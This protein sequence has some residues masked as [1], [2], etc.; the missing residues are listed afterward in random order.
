MLGRYSNRSD[1]GERIGEVLKSAPDAAVRP[2]IRTSPRTAR[3]LESQEIDAL[4]WAYSNGATVYELAQEFGIHRSTVS[5]V[6]EREGVA[7]RQRLLDGD[8]L[9]LARDLYTAGNTLAQVGQ[10]LGVSRSTVAH[11]LKSEGVQLRRRTA[12]SLRGSSSRSRSG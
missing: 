6:L 2:K 3:R 10:V 9:L 12:T 7:R 4:V 11:T 1:Q 8:R 5:V